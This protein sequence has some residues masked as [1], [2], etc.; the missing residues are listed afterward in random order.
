MFKADLKSQLIAKHSI[1]NVMYFASRYATVQ[2]VQSKPLKRQ[3][4]E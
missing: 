2:A 1:K 4:L 3:Y